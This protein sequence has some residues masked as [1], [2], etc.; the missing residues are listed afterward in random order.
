MAYHLSRIN[1]EIAKDLFKQIKEGSGFAVFFSEEP[2]RVVYILRAGLKTLYKEWDGLLTLRIK[3]GK[4]VVKPII[5]II[6][7]GIAQQH[8]PTSSLRTFMEIA[9]L[10]VTESPKV[11][12]FPDADLSEGD[13][14]S[15][16]KV[17]NNSF[18][19]ITLNPLTV[20]KQ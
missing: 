17:C 7:G 1:Q 3:E 16:T 12:S 9:S 18:Y 13:L 5:P 15:L 8:I 2:D 19:T 4:V 10:I 6:T 20:R 14:A 11:M